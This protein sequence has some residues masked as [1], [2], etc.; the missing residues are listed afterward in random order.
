MQPVHFDVWLDTIVAKD[1]IDAIEIELI[2]KVSQADRREISTVTEETSL[3]S[4][5]T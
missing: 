2:M 1:P 5:C 4:L 3:L